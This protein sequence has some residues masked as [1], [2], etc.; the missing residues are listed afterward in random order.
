MCNAISA[1]SI[2]LDYAEVCSTI[3]WF[4]QLLTY[5]MRHDHIH[6]HGIMMMS[7]H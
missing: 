1:S 4:K 5:N 2:Y 6:Q 7:D 3:R